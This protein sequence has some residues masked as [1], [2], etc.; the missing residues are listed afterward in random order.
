MSRA[1]TTITRGAE[2]RATAYRRRLEQYY[3]S[4]ICI[5]NI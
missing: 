1:I 3:I 4:K 2:L 5:K